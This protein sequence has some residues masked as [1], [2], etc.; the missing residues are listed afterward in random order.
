M[1]YN[2]SGDKMNGKSYFIKRAYGLLGRTTP[3]VS[4]CGRLCG[5]RCC[6]GDSETGMFLFPYEEEIIKNVENFKILDCEGNFGYKMVVCNDTCDRKTRPLACRIYPYF[7]VI[8]ENG[9][10]VRADIRGIGSCP[11]LY[12]NV[13]INYAF[14]RQIRKIARLFSSDEELKNY[15]ND[16]N[17]MLD[18]IEEFAERMI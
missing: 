4:D 5:G 18:E 6:K 13:K 3:L 7:P 16:I 2:V 15:I 8:T 10:D 9:F 17:A 12:E 1:I 11:L 14:I